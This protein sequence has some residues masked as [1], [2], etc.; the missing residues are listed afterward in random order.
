[1]LEAIHSGGNAHDAA[2]LL[3]RVAVGVFFIFSGYH[4]LFNKGRHES[5]VKTLTDDKVPLIKVNQWFVPSVEFLGGIAVTVGLFTSLAAL[6]LIVICLVATCVDGLKRVEGWSPIDFADKIDDVLY[7]PEV[8]Y[9]VMLVAI[10][11]A[12]SGKYSLHRWL[13]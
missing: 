6:G 11:M 3:V 5:L 10:V 4:K 2:M 9:L 8:L 12:G 13:F 1:M 7:L